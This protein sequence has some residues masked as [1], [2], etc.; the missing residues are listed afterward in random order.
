MGHSLGNEPFV[1]AQ[2]QATAESLGEDQ[3]R[4]RHA[5]RMT[6][7]I[8]CVSSRASCHTCGSL[9]FEQ[10]SATRQFVQEC[11]GSGGTTRGDTS[12][13]LARV[14]QPF[15]RCGQG[16]AIA[17]PESKNVRVA[18]GG[19]FA[20]SGGACLFHLRAAAG[21]VGLL[22]A[23]D[24]EPEW[25]NVARD[26]LHGRSPLHDA[27]PAVLR[28]GWQCCEAQILDEFSSASA[29]WAR[30]PEFHRTLV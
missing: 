1:E 13:S 10:P 29:A 18:H 28:H 3:A 12:G 2:W 20:L 26:R 5:N 24:R 21:R 27:T 30:L 15:R 23:R 16:G 14:R 7:P 9:A 25:L 4:P 8:Y 19:R 22:D 11:R 17:R 6:V